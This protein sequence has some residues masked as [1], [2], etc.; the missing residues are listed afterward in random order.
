MAVAQAQHKV[1]ELYDALTKSGVDVRFAHSSRCRTHARPHERSAG[2]SRHS[3][4]PAASKWMRSMATSRKPTSR[5]IIGAND[6]T[7]PAARTDTSQPHLRHADSRCR[8]GPHRHGHQAQHES[9][10]RRHRQPALLP[11]QH[12]DAVRRRQAVCDFDCEGV[13]QRTLSGVGHGE[14]LESAD[15]LNRHLSADLIVRAGVIPGAPLLSSL[16]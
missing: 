15:P 16:V 11:R 5:S 13:E 1:R 9:R 3:L 12:P 8:Q 10:L 7:N 6:V 2:R 14:T 4:R